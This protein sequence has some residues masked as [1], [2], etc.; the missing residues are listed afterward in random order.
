M[1]H[2]SS[3]SGLARFLPILSWVPRYQRMW[4]RPDL[5]A[6]ITVAALVVP[7]SLGYAGIA[8]VPIE[9]G[10]YAAAAGA[11]LY[12]I[13]GLS[14][15]IATGPSS[16]L[17]A[18]AA[19]AL[20]SAGIA[21]GSG[22]AVALV[23]AVTIASGLMF[24]VLRLFR[25]GWISQF[26]SKPVITGFLFGAAIEV[27]IGELPKITG[28][29]AEGTNSW[30]KLLSWVEGLSATDLTTVVVGVASLVL[31]F[32]LKV[33]AP[34]LPG[35]L[36]LLVLGL[37]ASIVLG[38][39][40]RGVT[41]IGE[42]P[43]GL[44][45]IAIPDPD[46]VGQNITVILTAAV[47]LLLIG[48]SQTA[49]DARS[50]ASKHGARVDIDQESVAQGAANIGSGLLQGIPVSTSLS[51]SSLADSS[52][53]KTQLASLTTGAVVVLTM[54]LLAPLFSD[55]PT[56]VLAAIIIQAVVSGMMDVPQMR[57]LYRVLRTDFWIA[58]IA[59]VS[60]L[61][62]GVLA[63]VV[64]GVFLSLGYL[65][66]ISASPAM[67]ELGRKPGTRAFR[68][69]D[70]EP[71]V[72]TYPGLLVMRIDSSLYFANSEAPED[73]LRELVQAADPSITHH[74]ARLRGHQ[75]HRLPGVRGHR[76]GHRS[77]RLQRHRHPPRPRQGRPGHARAGGRRGARSSR[78]ARRLPGGVRGRR[79][80]DRGRRC[81]ALSAM[82]PAPRARRR[83]GHMARRRRSA[84]TSAPP[85][86]K[87]LRKRLRKAEDQLL[88]A[89]AKRDRAQAR[90]E[91]LSII[92]DELRAQLAEAEK[93]ARSAQANAAGDHEATNG[94][95]SA[96]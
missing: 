61:T 65:I 63:G 74:R 40:E 52:G 37:A 60:V 19:G 22:D 15:Q 83:R 62:A 49:G 77:G 72:T 41:L 25:M 79:R 67:P 82:R 78:Y 66:Y 96:A 54:I 69:V 38:L 28:T 1:S 16:A 4:L 35:A 12:A 3:P 29:S 8:G 42:V 53:A 7:K 80:P 44:P 6:G 86:S 20:V 27:V 91:A 45:S 68:S 58:M 36:V 95:G 39:G 50:F 26:L 9:Y 84:G 30:Q 18:V 59:L 64:I 51:A 13:F 10:L 11:I 17:A 57:R 34:R 48:F 70:D 2:P 90:V 21:T 23:A 89:S 47:G 88:D 46:F 81:H 94:A 32:G 43:R 31:I 14:G 76:Q 24:L 71:E 55:L 33:A 85:T 73:R 92:A 93:A 75:L 56:A 5:I 87:Q